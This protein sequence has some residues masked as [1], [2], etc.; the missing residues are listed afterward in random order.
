MMVKSHLLAFCAGDARVFFPCPDADGVFA[1]A[2]MIRVLQSR[3]QVSSGAAV[4]GSGPIPQ[5]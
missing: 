4:V 5:S 1:Y 3:D 2:Q